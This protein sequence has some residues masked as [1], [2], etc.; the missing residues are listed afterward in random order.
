MKRAIISAR[1]SNSLSILH[2]A[3][4][5]G[6]AQA[7]V[8]DGAESRLLATIPSGVNVIIPAAYS[9]D[10]SRVAYVSRAGGMAWAVCGDWRGK[11]Y[12]VV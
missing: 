1:G 6:L 7:G 5:C 4:I 8:S 3:L 12:A 11:A 2:S 9:S 10:G